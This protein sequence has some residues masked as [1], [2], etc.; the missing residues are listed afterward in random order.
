VNSSGR[1]SVPVRN[2]APRIV[3]DLMRM[4]LAIFLFSLFTRTSAD[5]DLWGHVLFGQDILRTGSVHRVD[6]YSFTSDVP[7][8]NHEWLAEAALAAAYGWG[9]SAGLVIGKSALVLTML[10][11][12]L[13]VLRRG[14]SHLVPRDFL[15]FLA[16]IGTYGRAATFRPQVFSLALFALLL[17]IIRLAEDGHRKLLWAVPPLFLVWTNLHGGWIVGLGA[18]GLW[19]AWSVLRADRCGFGRSFLV[20][21]ALAAVLATLVNP[22]GWRLWQFLGETVR[23]SRNITE[24]QPLFTLPTAALIPWGTATV[25]ATV[26]IAY[27]RSSVNIGHVAIVAFYWISSIRVNRLDAFFVISVVMLLGPD[28]AAA[29]DGIRQRGR[30]ASRPPPG[31][32]KAWTA[33]AALLLGTVAV[34]LTWKNFECVSIEGLHEPEPHAARFVKA[35]RLEGRMLTNFNWGEYAI[36]HLNPRIKVSMDGR[37]ETV[38]SETLVTRHNALYQGKAG[39]LTLVD[40]LEPDYV[41]LPR[42]LPPL[43]NLEDRGWTRIFDGPKSTILSRKPVVVQAVPE[44]PTPGRRCFPDE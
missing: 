31:A 26:A 39:A 25:L 16:V 14:N 35:N 1:I 12:I 42:D 24:W 20:F 41:W 5:L 30:R 43:S 10:G 32:G 34:G 13:F 23:F 38:Y 4:S 22:Y 33:V 29:Y 18:F 27:R 36:W 37:R 28:I 7:W 21:V 40:D 9:G 17:L 15:V 19:S 8:I 2:R 11:A 3:L 44:L 6:P